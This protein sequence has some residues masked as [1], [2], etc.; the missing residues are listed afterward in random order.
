MNRQRQRGM[1]LLGWLFVLGIIAI[2][3][4]AALRL[5]PVYLEYYRVN[6]VLTGLKTEKADGSTSKK[7]IRDYLYNRFNIEAINRLKAS[8][9]SVTA[10]SE[11]Y[12]VRAKYDA[13]TPFIGNVHFIITFDKKVEIPR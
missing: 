12:E 6:A 3:A 2:F 10:K 4:I 8:D 11:F 7:E 9:L 1:T 5:V 13:R